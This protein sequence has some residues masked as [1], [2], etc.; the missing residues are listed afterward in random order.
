MKY[1][2]ILAMLT[3]CGVKLSGD[4]TVTHKIDL[5]ADWFKQYCAELYPENELAQAKCVNEMMIT[6]IKSLEKK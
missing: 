6:F 4:V 1:L 2:L 3:G 5:A